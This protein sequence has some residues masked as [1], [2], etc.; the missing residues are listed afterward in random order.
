MGP[1]WTH[2][3]QPT[4]EYCTRIKKMWTH[5]QI[6]LTKLTGKRYSPNK[7][8]RK[9]TVTIIQI[10]LFEIWQSRNN[11]KYDEKILPQHKNNK[12]NKCTIKNHHISTLQKTQT[13]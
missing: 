13:K 2:G 7:Y 9:L 5:Y 3:R 4:Q 1:L 10:I 6:I 12:Q 8:T 11:N